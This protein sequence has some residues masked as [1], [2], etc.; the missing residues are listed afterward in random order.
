MTT[1]TA[2]EVWE[3][4]AREVDP[5]GIATCQKDQPPIR[6]I[7]EVIIITNFKSKFSREPHRMDG[8]KLHLTQSV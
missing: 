3:T 5:S 6:E 4:T 1:V 8:E 2:A 7:T